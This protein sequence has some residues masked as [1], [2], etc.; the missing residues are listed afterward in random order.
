ML[1]HTF[2]G[3]ILLDSIELRTF[4]QVPENPED[5]E[6]FISKKQQYY[7][8][9][10]G[11]SPQPFVIACGPI[12]ALQKIY[13][14]IDNISYTCGSLL[15]AVDLCFK[16]IFAA[17]CKEYPTACRH[18]YSF[19]AKFV[20]ELKKGKPLVGINRKTTLWSSIANFEGNLLA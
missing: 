17:N 19:L 14:V 2:F 5:L 7:L 20:Y 15:E 4:L 18:I 12:D 13:V 10:N 6:A 8:E 11:T 9:N 1:Q 3:I 16:L